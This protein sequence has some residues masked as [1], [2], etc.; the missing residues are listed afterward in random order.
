MNKSFI[1]IALLALSFFQHSHIVNA[2]N[3]ESGLFA[4]VGLMSHSYFYEGSFGSL[5]IEPS[6]INTTNTV[7]IF[8][9]G[10]RYDPWNSEVDMS[11]YSSFVS[12]ADT[13]ADIYYSKSAFSLDYHYNFKNF[14]IGIN[15]TLQNE[16][17]LKIFESSSDP[18]PNKNDGMGI[19]FGWRYQNF[20]FDLKKE[21]FIIFPDY[22]PIEMEG[23]YEYWTLRL[24]RRFYFKKQES[25]INPNQLNKNFCFQFGMLSSLNGLYFNENIESQPV[26]KIL[27]TIGIEARVPKTDF[28]VYAR[29][30]AL[31]N[32][33]AFNYN[34][35]V[36]AQVNHVGAS[37][38]LGKKEQ[39]RLGLHY[40][41]HMDKALTYLDFV[42]GTGENPGA[43]FVYENQGIGASFAYHF[44]SNFSIL[45]N[46]DFYYKANE[47]LGKGFNAE[48]IKLGIMYNLY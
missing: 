1:R 40:V 33:E 12:G 15:Y 47:R 2:Q 35:L 37:Y 45:G 25:Q 38:Q 31:L 14:R 19:S 29:R 16:K 39:L 7:P 13:V 22:K 6:Y 9:V 43:I 36:S 10:Y 5:N 20:T 41:W 42:D 21:L 27:P 34:F 32:V 3:K 28:F 23:L 44:D 11:F 26:A 46:V 48:S 30:S 17:H 4:T 24:S 8:S 18:K